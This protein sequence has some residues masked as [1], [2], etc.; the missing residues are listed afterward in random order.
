MEE[1]K[2]EPKEDETKKLIGDNE[3]NKELT[4]KLRKDP[5]FVAF[6]KWATDNGAIFPRVC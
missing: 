2:K 3:I 1:R 5:K 4:E 6:N